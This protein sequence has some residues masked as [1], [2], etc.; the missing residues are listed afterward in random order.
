MSRAA[1]YLRVSTAEQ[2]TRAFSEEGYSI[3][4]QREAC[5]RKAAQLEADVVGEYVDRGESARSAKRPEL[6][7]LL[8][9]LGG[10]GDLD[11]VIVHKIDRLARNLADHV[12]ITLAIKAGGAE[13]V[14]VVEQIDDTPLGEY[15]Q[16]IFAAN[17]QLYSANLSAE[18]KK[19]LHQ[20][21]KKGGTPGPA[22]LGYLNVRTVVEG[23]E[24]KTVEPDPERAPHITW[25]F[26]AYASGLYTLDRLHAKLAERGLVTRKTRKYAATPVSRAHLARILRNPYYVGTVR[27]GG[28]EYEGRHTP[29]VDK[30]TFSRVEGV[31]TAH[32]AANERNRRWH[33]F[34]KGSLVC[35]RCGSRLTFAKAKGNGGT[36]EYFAC[37]G[38]IQRAC[39]LPYA[40][41]EA[42]EARVAAE[43]AKVKFEQARA[44]T[45]E[46]WV[47]HLD[48][49]RAA[50]KQSIS[51]LRTHNASEIRTQKRRITMIKE[52][53]RK[54]LD[55]FLDDALSTAVLQQKQSALDRELAGAARLLKL[56]EQD[57]VELG[58]VLDEALDLARDCERA[59][60]EVGPSTRRQLNQALFEGFMVDAE[61]I[62][63]AP[64]REEVRLLTNRDTPRRLRAE[65]RTVAS[66]GLGSNKTLLAEREGF[67]PS[68]ELA[69]PTRLAG[70]CLQPLGH[71]SGRDADCRCKPG[72]RPTRKPACA[73]AARPSGLAARSNGGRRRRAARPAAFR[74][75]ARRT[76]GRRTR[77]RSRCASGS[78][79][80]PPSRAIRG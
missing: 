43:Y 37:I 17:A 78:G 45:H 30:D 33:H 10:E 3:E 61:R 22:P 52:Q 36:Y 9:R 62:D 11:Y 12:E 40:P 42:T 80:R 74:P 44:D 18:A 67:E 21:A 68:R 5:R 29:L 46:R 71:L 66:S 47:A 35:A 28:V 79:R 20:K 34:L 4:A 57:G 60:G 64:L 75:R 41:V 72:T 13:L 15:M 53:Q 54:L 49:V 56:A 51:G 16:T 14:S 24:I 39:T 6:Q 19:G 8:A 27:Y 23:I 70:E 38:R 2:T 7:A 63:E 1:L 25:A 26:A 31:L 55:A 65:A 58:E 59:Y 32:G 77:R 48:D 69:P 73:P 76:R 50:L